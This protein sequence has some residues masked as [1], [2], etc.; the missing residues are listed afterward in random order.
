FIE[1]L[2]V[3]GFEGKVRPICTDI[4]PKQLLTDRIGE[5]G[6]P[7][8]A[9]ANETLGRML[10]SINFGTMLKGLHLSTV[11]SSYRAVE[12]R[13]DGIVLH[14]TI[15]LPPWK[16]ARHVNDSLR[17]VRS[18]ESV[19]L[20]DALA[21]WIPGGT[22]TSFRWYGREQS[23]TEQHQFVTFIKLDPSGPA[24]PTCLEI[25]GPQTPDPGA[26]RPVKRRFCKILIPLAGI[27][28]SPNVRNVG[29]PIPAQRP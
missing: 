20:E 16:D 9:P 6:R 4:D 27:Q 8:L 13:P 11:E 29:G 22:I 14:G 3:T 10:G 15:A 1:P 21:S 2:E 18:G 28:P 24:A 26:T 19:L 23:V 7:V 5:I 12:I 25:V 17:V